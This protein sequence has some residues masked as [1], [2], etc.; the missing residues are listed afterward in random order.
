M[1]KQ[2]RLFNEVLPATLRK[3]KKALVADLDKLNGIRN[4]V[5]HP[6]K[7]IAVTEDDLVFV[8]DFYKKV[9]LKNW[10]KTA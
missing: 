10:G 5:M 3:D 9:Q 7:G 8:R 4:Y 6:V 1:D 2:W